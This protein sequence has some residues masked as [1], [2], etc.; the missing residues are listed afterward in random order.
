MTI[1]PSRAELAELFREDDRHQ[2]EHRQFMASPEARARALLVRKS[3]PDHGL[4]YRTTN[5]APLSVLAVDSGAFHEEP[6]PFDDAQLDVLAS[7]INELRKEFEQH[8]KI[9][10]VQTLG[11]HEQMIA[12]LTGKVDTLIALLGQKSGNVPMGTKRESDVI[13]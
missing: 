8:T 9:H 7:V 12:Q 2:A 1:P 6:D 11:D 13:D 10:A 4:T 3:E 5:N